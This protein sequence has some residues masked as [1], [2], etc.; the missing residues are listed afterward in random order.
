MLLIT[1]YIMLPFPLFQPAVGNMKQDNKQSGC[2][3]NLT[4]ICQYEGDKRQP[5]LASAFIGMDCVIS[6]GQCVAVHLLPV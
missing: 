6:C 4:A 2:L 5:I 3:H 1:F